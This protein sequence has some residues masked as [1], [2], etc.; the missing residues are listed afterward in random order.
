MNSVTI[1]YISKQ[2]L[3]QLYLGEK[4]QNVFTHIT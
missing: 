4:F 1:V 3:K 2:Y